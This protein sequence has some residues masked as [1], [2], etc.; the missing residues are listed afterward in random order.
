MTILQ[1]TNKIKF[2]LINIKIKLNAYIN[3]MLHDNL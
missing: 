2:S 3:L 1:Q